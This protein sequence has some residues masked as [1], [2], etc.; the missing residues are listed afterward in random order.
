[1]PY[2]QNSSYVSTPN[3]NSSFSTSLGRANTNSSSS[4][5]NFSGSSSCV[6]KPTTVTWKSVFVAKQ[7]LP[8]RPG[9]LKTGVMS[10][11]FY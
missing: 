6:G 11:G 8:S 10:C 4:S 3:W 2:V 5:S 9:F 1:M 7:V